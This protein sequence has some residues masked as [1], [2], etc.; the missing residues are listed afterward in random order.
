M[1]GIR[2]SPLAIPRVGTTPT[3]GLRVVVMTHTKGL[4]VAAATHT[5][6]TLTSIMERELM[7]EAI[8]LHRHRRVVHTIR[9]TMHTCGIIMARHHLQAMLMV[10]TIHLQATGIRLPLDTHMVIH[11]LTT[12]DIHHRMVT[13]L[14]H[15]A[16]HFRRTLA[17]GAPLPP[18]RRDARLLQAEKDLED[19]LERARGRRVGT[20]G[21][22]STAAT[23]KEVTEAKEKETN[24]LMGETVVI[25][26]VPT[27]G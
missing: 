18:V 12:G 2:I 23:L 22:K 21:A 26:M 9:I 14:R 11:R 5:I 19:Q 10:A 3:R 1:N 7:E 6:D 16:M 13:H 24:P 27:F 25:S 4:P 8:T 15:M 17:T 20:S